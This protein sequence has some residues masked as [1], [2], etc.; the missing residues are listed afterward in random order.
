M[1][2]NI[3]EQTTSIKLENIQPTIN[4]YIK[5]LS[6]IFPNKAH[7]LTFFEPV[8]S[9]GKKAVSGDLDLAIDFTHIIRAF[10]ES[11]I[12]LWGVDYDTWY[13]RYKSIHKRSRTATYDMCKMRALLQL[14]GEQMTEEG[15]PVELKKVNAG[16]LFSCFPQFGPDNKPTG[17]YVQIDWMVGDID[18]LRWA[19]YSHGEQGLKGL[20]RTQLILSCFTEMGMSFSHLHGI[21]NKGEVEWLIEG[22]Q[23]A[24][25]A[26]AESFGPITMEQTNTFADFH[27]WIK[28]SA[29]Q[30]QYDS[31][32]KRYLRIL[33]IARAD[34]P[35]QLKE[36]V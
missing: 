7:S 14:I 24:L 11:N 1:G 25:E 35:E 21:K 12:A 13:E 17:E 36:L 30:E 32:I 34:I 31:I 22:P 6:K 8:G 26:L 2:G 29:N 4:A 33:Q 18:W 19:Y 16:N 10:T 9:T 20:H 28:Q 23:I 15:I 3:F 5:S 27:S